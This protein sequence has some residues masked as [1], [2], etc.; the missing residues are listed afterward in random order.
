MEPQ[1]NQENDVIEV[2]DPLQASPALRVYARERTAL[3]GVPGIL[4]LV[5]TGSICWRYV[6]NGAEEIPQLLA[7]ALSSIIGFYFGA[8][9]S[10]S[11]PPPNSN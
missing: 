4:A 10:G 7:Y 3:F 6:T 8:G 2:G 9:V 5:I 1:D 11:R